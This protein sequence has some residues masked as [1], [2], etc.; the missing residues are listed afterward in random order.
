MLEEKTVIDAITYRDSGHIEVRQAALILRDG[1]EINKQYHRH[2]VSPGDDLTGEDAKVVAMAEAFWTPEL[3][4]EYQAQQ[5][6]PMRT[7]S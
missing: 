3:I 4:A 7:S 6:N 1:V 2:V 5:A